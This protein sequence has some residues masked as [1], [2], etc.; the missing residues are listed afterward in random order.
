[1]FNFIDHQECHFSCNMVDRSLFLSPVILHNVHQM[2]CDNCTVDR[3][4]PGT[5]L[6]ELSD[7]EAKS[8]NM[9]NCKSRYLTLSW[10]TLFCFSPFIISLTHIISFLD[11][12]LF[13]CPKTPCCSKCSIPFQLLQ[14]ANQ[15][16]HLKI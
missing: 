16:L 10:Y 6:T 9:Q 3:D 2:S 15:I 8:L 13:S 7:C 4:C 14:L 1:M 11:K 5:C 12:S